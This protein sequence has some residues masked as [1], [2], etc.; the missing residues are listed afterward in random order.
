MKANKVTYVAGTGKVHGPVLVTV[1]G[2]RPLALTVDVVVGDGN[3]VGSAGSKNNV[4]AA[5]VGGS[6]VV[7]PDKIRTINLDSITSPNVLRV[8]LSDVDVLNDDVLSALDV[9]TLALDNTIGTD[10]DNGL[11]RVDDN[12][13]QSSLIVGNVDL[14]GVGLVVVAPAVLVD[15]LLAICS[16]APRS[17][18]LLGGG[19]LSSG[20]VELLIEEDDSGC[21][22]TEHRDQLVG[23]LGVGSLS[24]ASTSGFG[25]KALGCTS[26]TG[27]GNV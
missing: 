4:L 11:V 2:S 9:K 6:N 17:T 3:S 14:R 1:T 26:H 22:V 19:S 7:D 23:G 15:G 18:A 10:A 5:N 21:A 12:R 20:K 25:G 24:V 27:G 8:Q 13:V 16:S